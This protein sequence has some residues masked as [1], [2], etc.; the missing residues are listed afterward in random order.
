M[1][2]L[3]L[4]SIVVRSGSL[5]EAEVD[6]EVVALHIDKGTCYGLNEVGSRI[7]QLI[8]TPTMIRDLSTKLLSEFRVDSATCEKQVLSLLEEL[9]AE[10]M[11]EVRR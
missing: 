3:S 1:H 5:L 4:E 7:W 10:G 11:I 2:N 9:H 6:G 8:A